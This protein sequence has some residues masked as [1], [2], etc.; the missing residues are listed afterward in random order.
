MNIDINTTNVV[1]YIIM[2]LMGLIT[3]F[4]KQT[5]D[6]IKKQIDALQ[7][8]DTKLSEDIHRLDKTSISRTDFEKFRDELKADHKELNKTLTD[9]LKVLG[10]P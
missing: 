3:Y 7:A 6:G 1:A 5:V 8:V 4:L 2:A 10:K 9:I